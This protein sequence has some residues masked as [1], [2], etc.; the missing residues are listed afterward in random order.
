[1]ASLL[2]YK[3]LITGLNKLRVNA[4]AMQ[5]DLNDNWA[6]LAEAVQT[7]MRKNDIANPYEKLKLLPEASILLQSSTK[8]LCKI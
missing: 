3:S 2:A 7:I 8:N 1:M 4:A 6:I 5:A